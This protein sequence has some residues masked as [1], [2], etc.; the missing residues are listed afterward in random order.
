MCHIFKVVQGKKLHPVVLYVI[1]LKVDLCMLLLKNNWF[2][3][4]FNRLNDTEFSFV[5]VI[6]HCISFS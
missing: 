3:D 5:E 1:L 2:Y 6:H 4:T